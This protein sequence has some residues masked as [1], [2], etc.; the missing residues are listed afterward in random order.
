[1]NHHDADI[2]RI[3]GDW[4]APT[5]IK[6]SW[7]LNNYSKI[8]Q[9]WDITQQHGGKYVKTQAATIGEGFLTNVIFMIKE[10]Q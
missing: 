6:T 2:M 9:M 5:I 4:K 7:S 3:T 10:D 1:M 8:S